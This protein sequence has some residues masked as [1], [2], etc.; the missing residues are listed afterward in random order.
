MYWFQPTGGVEPYGPDRHPI[1]IHEDADG[2][3]VYG[4]PAI[5]G[6]DGGAKVAFFRHGTPCTPDTIDREVH[7]AEVA[8]MAEHPWLGC[9]PRCPAGTSLRPPACTPPRRTSTA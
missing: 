8:F 7:P 9:C 4:F 2:T 1:Y 6:P 3:Q 5:D